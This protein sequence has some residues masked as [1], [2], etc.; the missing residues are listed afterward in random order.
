MHKTLCTV[1]VK[2]FAYLC[3]PTDAHVCRYIRTMLPWKSIP[4]RVIFETQEI[5]LEKGKNKIA[6]KIVFTEKEN[7][8]KRRYSFVLIVGIKS[9][10]NRTDK[11]LNDGKVT[12]RIFLKES[13]KMCNNIIK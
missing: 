4:C 11:E 13:K 1:N 8:I 12:N 2:D 10:F 5:H 9:D 7:V 6:Q 3:Q